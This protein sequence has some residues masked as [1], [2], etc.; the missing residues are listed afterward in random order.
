VFV[1]EVVR[2]RTFRRRYL[3]ERSTPVAVLTSMNRLLHERRLEEYSCTLCYA[4]FDLRRR[5]VT[6]ANSGL[7]YPVRS[8][9]SGTAPLVLPGVPLGWFEGS[10]YDEVTMELSV[11]DV[12]AFCTDGIF[13]AM[14]ASG[15]EFGAGRL[16]DVVRDHRHLPSQ[17]IVE[18][19]FTAVNGFRDGDDPRDDMTVVVVKI[20]Q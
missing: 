18:A 15:E 10:E 13:E 2:S 11:G 14:D 19:I 4:S 8:T 6:V 16:N 9:G 7:P 5:T 1:A 3:P 20:A 17:D 12:F